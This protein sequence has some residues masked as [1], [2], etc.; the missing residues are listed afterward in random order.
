M[1]DLFP[2]RMTKIRTPSDD[3]GSQTLIAY[4]RQI[5]CVSD[6]LLPLLMAGRATY[7]EDVLSMF[8]IAYYV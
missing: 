1:P 8:G 5:A 4:E 3:D 2:I 6:L 7:S